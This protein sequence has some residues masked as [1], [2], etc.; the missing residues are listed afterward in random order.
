MKH[1]A[2]AYLVMKNHGDKDIYVFIFDLGPYWQVENANHGTYTVITPQKNGERDKGTRKK[3]RMVIP[4]QM[5]EKGHR[6]CT[7]ILKVFVTSQ[8]MSFDLLELPRLG[9]QA[10]TLKPNRTGGEG[11]DGLENWVAMN[12][13]IHISLQEN[14]CK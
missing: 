11:H 14:T 1:N 10:K 3:L 2:I 12:F 8:P 7:D 9:G 5:R 13:S 4:D 6:S